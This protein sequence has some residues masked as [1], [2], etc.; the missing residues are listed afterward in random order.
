VEARKMLDE[1]FK[2]VLKIRKLTR[3]AFARRLIKKDN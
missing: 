3:D 1:P 2:K